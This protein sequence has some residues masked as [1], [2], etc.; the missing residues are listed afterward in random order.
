MLMDNENLKKNISNSSNRLTIGFF[1]QSSTGAGGFQDAVWNSMIKAAKTYDVNLFVFAGGAVDYAPYNPFEKN[2]NLIYDLVNKESIDGL[3]ISCTIGNFISPDRFKEFCDQFSPIPLISIIGHVKGLPDV[4]LNNKDGMEDIITHL[5]NHHGFKRLA[6]IKG[7]KDNT[8]A[9]ERFNVYKDVL[10][11]NGKTYD[12][13]LVYNGEFNEDSG[14]KA[15]N[16]FIKEKTN[17]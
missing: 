11:K 3:I 7:P 2:L 5:I 6:F 10:K 17:Q 13:D 4:H 8:D 12:P 1:I 14:I 9:E 15:V 16:Y